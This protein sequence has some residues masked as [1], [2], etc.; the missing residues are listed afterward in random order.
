MQKAVSVNCILCLTI[1][2]KLFG[3][4]G[5]ACFFH[6]MLSS[7]RNMPGLCSQATFYWLQCLF[8]SLIYPSLTLIL[9]EVEGRLMLG[10][11]RNLSW[12]PGK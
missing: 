3:H 5:K 6:A 9:E 10:E 4:S 1:K 12:V 7:N 11:V 2:V 8:K